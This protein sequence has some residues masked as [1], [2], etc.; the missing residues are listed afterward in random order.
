MNVGV[1]PLSRIYATKALRD[2][3]E[4][5]RR[6]GAELVQNV[7]GVTEGFTEGVA[8]SFAQGFAKG[9]A[10]NCSYYYFYVYKYVYCVVYVYKLI[11]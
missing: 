3:T 7:R 4:R 9:Y 11:N 8:Q 5:W 10:G 1:I 6:A 2:G